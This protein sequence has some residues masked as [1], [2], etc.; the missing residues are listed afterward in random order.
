MFKRA[1]VVLWKLR[2]T[3]VI[4]VD[5]IGLTWDYKHTIVCR[6]LPISLFHASGWETFHRNIVRIKTFVFQQTS[7]CSLCRRSE[8]WFL[9]CYANHLVTSL[10]F[11]VSHLY[12]ITWR[13]DEN[14]GSSGQH[15]VT[16]PQPIVVRPLRCKQASQKG[17]P[18]LSNSRCCQ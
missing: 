9:Y 12:S 7:Q 3:A 5:R 17:Q 16:F 15:R 11:V 2:F 1:K 18:I 10:P 13:H 14:G 4:K 8:Q 6:C